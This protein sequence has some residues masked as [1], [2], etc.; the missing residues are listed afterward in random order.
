SR[1]EG[2][3]RAVE[4]CNGNGACRKHKGGTMCPSYRATR[5]EKDTT[6]ARANALRLAIGGSADDPKAAERDM[7]E[8]WVYEVMDLCLM[9]KA[10]KAECPSNVDVAKLKAEF[11][12]AYYKRHQRPLGH[13]LMAHIHWVNRLSAP[14]APLVNWLGRNKWSRWLME[15]TAG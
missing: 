3:T 2:F 1:Q 13:Y 5:D 8:R 11:L 9:C 10:C 4:M 14:V 15:L 7:A 6:R 12:H